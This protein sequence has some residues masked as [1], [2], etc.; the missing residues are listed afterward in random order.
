MNEQ[1]FMKAHNMTFRNRGI[2]NNPIDWKM[3]VCRGKVALQ[4]N[5]LEI[6]QLCCNFALIY[7]IANLFLRSFKAS[8]RGEHISDR[9]VE[10]FVA[11]VRSVN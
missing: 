6:I 4:K 9:L 3:M 5:D 2:D 10:A 7:K 11:C 1:F 8:L